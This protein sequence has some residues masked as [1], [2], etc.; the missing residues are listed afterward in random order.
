M[1]RI[2]EKFPE[3]FCDFVGCEK[4]LKDPIIFPCGETLCKEH[5]NDA[6]EE[7]KC[8][9][10]HRHFMKPDKGFKVNIKMN[11][12]TK[13]F[14]NSIDQRKRVNIHFDEL[15]KEFEDLKKMSSRRQVIQHRDKMI[16]IVQK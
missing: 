15:E 7:F 3:C 8:P 12:L 6:G 11:S 1:E 4:V 9:F 10:C 14:A 16:E 2:K 5:V 13:I